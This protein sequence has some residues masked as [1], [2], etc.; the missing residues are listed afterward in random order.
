MMQ[1]IVALAFG[2]PT[3][4][5]IKADSVPD[6]LTGI[7]N[8]GVH[9][10]VPVNLLPFFNGSIASTN[11]NNLAV[12]I[13]WLDDGGKKPLV[14]FMSNKT[15]TVVLSPASNE[16]RLFGH[17]YTAFGKIFGCSNPPPSPT[18]G[19]PPNPAYVHKF[20]DLN[21]TEIGHFINQLTLSA[22]FHGFSPTD[23]QSLELLMNGRYNTRCA[24]A[25]SVDALQP[26]QLFSIC[27][28]P[29]CP[30]AVPNSDCEAYHNIT[31]DG[32]S[33]S[34]SDPSNPATGTDSEPSSGSKG[35]SGGG[36][37]GVVIG[38]VALIAFIIAAIFYLRR[39]RRPKTPPVPPQP[40]TQ[41]A[42]NSESFIG[43]PGQGFLSPQS[44]HFSAHSPNNRDSYV[45]NA[46][47]SYSPRPVEIGTPKLPEHQEEPVELSGERETAVE[48]SG[49]TMPEAAAEEFRKSRG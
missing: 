38:A 41:W 45:S 34:P 18:A 4:D 49:E 23:A 19:G 48:L 11:L 14:D 7:L 36:I 12:G 27:Q 40:E 13:N 15:D 26:P 28:N 17:F 30:L 2:G 33:S 24:P 42:G 47:T 20:M 25:M 8:P 10:G 32:V 9:D 46:H 35:L 1:G 21:F 31:A 29:T 3:A 37:A 22:E 16:Y 5:S 6:G 43:S 44:E 39:K